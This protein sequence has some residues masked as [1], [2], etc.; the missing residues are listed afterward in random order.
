M[1]R[2]C[3]AYPKKYCR[4]QSNAKKKRKKKK[5][6]LSLYIFQYSSASPGVVQVRKCRKKTGQIAGKMKLEKCI[7]DLFFT[8]KKY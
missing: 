1:L 5:N 4:L 2:S 7:D 6:V 8:W 3:S